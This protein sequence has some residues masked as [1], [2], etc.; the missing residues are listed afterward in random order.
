MPTAW[1]RPHWPAI[2]TSSRKGRGNICSTSGSRAWSARHFSLPDAV[3]RASWSYHL[4]LARSRSAPTAEGPATAQT[5]PP[6]LPGPLSSTPCD[7]VP[8]IS[9][10]CDRP[11]S[12]NLRAV[13]TGEFHHWPDR[14]PRLYQRRG[15]RSPVLT[16]AP[17]P[18]LSSTSCVMKG[19]RSSNVM[20][21]CRRC[22]PVHFA[23]LST[24]GQ[25]AL[26]SARSRY[27]RI[28]CRCEYVTEG[29]V[30]D[31]IAAAPPRWTASSFAR[32]PARGRMPG[33]LLHGA[34]HGFV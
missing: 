24:M 5:L 4:R 13:A 19:S 21:L 22:P 33:R 31:A 28:V 10:R 1:Q 26:S 11:S 2:S 20:T 30:L 8:G 14:P 3:S 29:E 27:R 6:A 32:A 9:G 15:H 23:A 7:L 12:P 18:S 25:I 16:A 17:S 34:L